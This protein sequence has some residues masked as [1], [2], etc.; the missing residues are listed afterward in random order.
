MPSGM[1][2]ISFSDKFK[3]LSILSARKGLEGRLEMRFWWRSNTVVHVGRF[4]G[5]S[6]NSRELQSTLVPRQLQTDGQASL[7]VV[8]VVAS[9]EEDEGEEDEEEEADDDP[10]I[11]LLFA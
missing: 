5:I 8:D 4:F 3:S 6:V 9:E 7:V 10:S 2:P 11:L 1:T